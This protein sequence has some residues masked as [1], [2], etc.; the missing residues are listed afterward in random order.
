MSR[1]E[2]VHWFITGFLAAAL[3]ATVAA[4]STSGSEDGR[5]QQ[6]M[7]LVRAEPNP[8]IM[9]SVLDTRTSEVRLEWADRQTR[10]I[11]PF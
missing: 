8:D 1:R 5:F 7:I 10:K 11:K 3:L 6:Q 4:A 2:K 9:V